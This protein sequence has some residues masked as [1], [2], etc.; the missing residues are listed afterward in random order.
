MKA[1][2]RW[3]TTAP[4]V[5]VGLVALFGLATLSSNLTG[6]CRRR[7]GTLALGPLSGLAAAGAA[8]GLSA[9]GLAWVGAGAMLRAPVAT[10]CAVLGASA[11]IS[12]GIGLPRR[13]RWT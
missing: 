2:Q 12:L 13:A 5:A 4:A 10:G 7:P 1:G 3:V 8:L 9:A 6:L 11:A